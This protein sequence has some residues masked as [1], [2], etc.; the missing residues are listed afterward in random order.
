M[1]ANRPVAPLWRRI[2][3]AE[4]VAEYLGVI[5][6]MYEITER[7]VNSV[8]QDG[9]LTVVMG[10]DL[11]KTYENPQSFPDRLDGDLAD[12]VRKRS[13]AFSTSSKTGNMRH[14]PRGPHRSGLRTRASG[15]GWTGRPAV[16]SESAKV[17]LVG[18]RRL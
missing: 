12:S 16:G 7:K 6:M 18:R 13:V 4:R 1:V 15:N 5:P 9:A 2:K 8:V 14:K 3:G 10:Q 11:A 17:P